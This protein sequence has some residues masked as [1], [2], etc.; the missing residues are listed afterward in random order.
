MRHCHDL[1]RVKQ[2]GR[3]VWQGD[4]MEVALLQGVRPDGEMYPRAGEIPFDT[5]RKRMSVICETPH[6]HMLYCK[7][8]LETVLPLCD[9]MLLNGRP[10]PLDEARRAS[11]VAMQEQMAEQGLRVIAFAHRRLPQ[12]ASPQESELIFTA[13][14]GL[15]DPPRDGVHKAVNTCHEAGIRVIMITGD[16]PETRD[17]DGTRATRGH[18]RPSAPHVRYRPATAC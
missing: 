3:E 6:G 2:N 7:G 4:P 1:R 13:L 5:G 15:V 18:R 10:Q 17:R 11:L 14:I 12:E 8:A 16:H 9:T